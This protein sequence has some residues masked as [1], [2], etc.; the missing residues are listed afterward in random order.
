MSSATT[1]HAAELPDVDPDALTRLERFGGSK[2]LREMI[3]LFVQI[4]PTRLHAAQG[5]VAEGRLATAE[6]ELHSLK[7]SAAQLGAMRL[8]RLSDQGELLARGGMVTGITEL[9]SEC[10][11]ELMR[12]E[13]WLAGER[14]A[15]GA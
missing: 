5:A 1:R 8:S 3:A 11:T 12:V 15:R 4:A 14:E 13:S 2:L 9:L 6:N 7:S 10:R